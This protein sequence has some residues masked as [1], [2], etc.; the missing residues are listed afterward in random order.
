MWLSHGHEKANLVESL[1]QMCLNVFGLQQCSV[2][3]YDSDL[4]FQQVL[5]TMCQHPQS[6]ALHHLACSNNPVFQG[7]G[8]AFCLSRELC[9]CPLVEVFG[10][11]PRG[12]RR[13]PAG[14]APTLC[15]A[16]GARGGRPFQFDGAW[17]PTLGEFSHLEAF[18]A[19]IW[20]FFS[21]GLKLKV[22][23]KIQP[24]KVGRSCQYVPVRHIW[25]CSVLGSGCV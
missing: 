5:A 18:G 23:R 2:I 15:R 11:K 16:V 6:A 3:H 8:Q 17:T 1:P 10:R 20:G 22:Q 25:T 9:V 4:R 24:K 7:R 12:E 14:I 19:V 21:F 13:E